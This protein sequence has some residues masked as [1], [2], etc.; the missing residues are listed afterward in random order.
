MPA[1]RLDNNPLPVRRNDVVGQDSDSVAEFVR[2]AA[3]TAAEH[4]AVTLSVA[5]PL[6]DMG[7]PLAQGGDEQT[8]QAHGSVPLTAD[9]VAQIDLFVDRIAAE[10]QANRAGKRQQY[11][12]HPHCAPVTADD[13]T[14]IYQRFSCGGFVL[15]AYRFVGIDLVVTEEG[16]LPAVAI[17]ILRLAY[18]DQQRVLDSPRLREALG[19]TGTGPWP[20]LLAGYVLHSLRRPEA[21]IRGSPYQPR[22]GDEYFP[23]RPPQPPPVPHDAAA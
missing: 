8:F 11:V 13:G 12:V 17:D 21:E 1:R 22:L 15:E 4:S 7:P 20:I 23:A 2:H 5:L 9:E 18:P 6:T 10:Y 14:V 16:T 19:L 3:L